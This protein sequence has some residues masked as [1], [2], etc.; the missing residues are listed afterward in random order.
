MTRVCLAGATG[1]VGAELCR[2][3]EASTDLRLVA[4]VA[5]KSAGRPLREVVG[6]QGDVTISASVPEALRTPCDVMVD[7]TAADAVFAH[8]RTALARGVAVVVGSSGLTEDQFAEIDTLARD[9]GV[10]V[11]ACG[12]FAITAILL[13][14]LAVMAARVV[15]HWEIIDYASATKPDAPSGTARELAAKLAEVAPPRHARDVRDTVGMV[16]SRGASVRGTQVHSVR[17]PGYTFSFEAQ[18][19]V[20]GE[21]LLIRHDAGD[22]AVPYVQGTLRAIHEVRTFAGLRRGMELG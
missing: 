12:N 5:R 15:P 11:L 4:A 19:G 16:E 17:L 3:L 20:S 8:V 14:K 9:R 6:V 2:A 1:W 13:Q 22:S 10:G 18:F 21:R 7:Y